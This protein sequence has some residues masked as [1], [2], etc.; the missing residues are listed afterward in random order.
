M[1]HSHNIDVEWD[2]NKNRLNQ[3]KHHVSFE[4]AATVFDDPLEVTIPDPD[5]SDSE[6]RFISL[7]Q[8]SSQRLLVVSYSE[9]AARIRI[10]SARTPTNSER[11]SYEEIR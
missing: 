1:N 11:R 10:I 7:G 4:E 8:S 5:H 2:E 3:R 9:R 6:T